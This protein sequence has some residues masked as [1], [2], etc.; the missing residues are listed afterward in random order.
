M[1]NLAQSE[2][3][4]IPG[5]MLDPYTRS[6]VF[7]DHRQLLTRIEFRLLEQLC[8]L[9]GGLIHREDLLRN[10]W[11]IQISVEPRTVD[12]HIVRLRKKLRALGEQAPTIQTVWGLGY[13]LRFSDHE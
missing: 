5:L 6:V 10:V 11:G 1:K 7:R 2:F 8:K 4:P 12:S 9:Q 13:R 3:Q